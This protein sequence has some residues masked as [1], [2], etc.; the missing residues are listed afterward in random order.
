M[1]QIEVN[2]IQLCELHSILWDKSKDWM[3]DNLEWKS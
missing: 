2:G 3:F 1:S